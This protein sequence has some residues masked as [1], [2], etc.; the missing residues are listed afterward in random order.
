MVAQLAHVGVKVRQVSHT[1]HGVRILL[2]SNAATASPPQLPPLLLPRGAIWADDA[3][4]GVQSAGPVSGASS[5]VFVCACA[6]K[7]AS[8]LMKCGA[9]AANVFNLGG[10]QNAAF[11]VRV[12][13]NVRGSSLIKSATLV[14]E[15]ARYLEVAP[16]LTT[17]E[18]EQRAGV[19]AT[20]VVDASTQWRPAFTT[21]L[22]V[23]GL[24][25]SDEV[26]INVTAQLQA[27][28]N[29]RG[30]VPGTYVS[31]RVSSSALAGVPY[32]ASLS[33]I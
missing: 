11:V 7:W 14:L 19:N 21:A 12:P 16:V 24:R 1:A 4:A 25:W 29:R 2:S 10:T 23:S 31:I 3:A 28:V 8:A 26:H 5:R 30:F 33:S 9:Y 13:V 20:P 18:V 6:F 22:D 32:G 15:A 17:V 27:I